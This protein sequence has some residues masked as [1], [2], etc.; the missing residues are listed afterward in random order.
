[1]SR[2]GLEPS[3]RSNGH[4]QMSA[5]RPAMERRDLP[6][7]EAYL[8]QVMLETLEYARE[9]DYTGYD[10]FDGMSSRVLRALPVDNKWVNIAVQESIKR[11]PVN[12]RPYF[13]VEQRQN[14]KGTALFSMA[15]ETAYSLTGDEMYREESRAL[16]DW[17]VDN[18]ADGYA[19]FCGGH[20]HEMQQLDERRPA[21]TPNVVPT[22]Y[23]VKALLRAAEYEGDYATVA[24]TAA[25]FVDEDLKYR[26]FDDGARIVY[27]PYFDGEFYTLNG[28][29]VG[30]R[31]H[32]DL[33]E[34]FGDPA[35]LDRARKLLD[36]IATKQTD[37]GGW[38]YRDPASASHLSMDNH[39][40][41][42]V[43]ESYLRYQEVAGDERYRDTVER[44]LQF[45][46]EYL[47]D[48]NGAPNWDEQKAYPKDI[49]AATQ[50]IIVFSKAGE[51]TFAR[52]IIDWV[53]ANL[54][55]G[56]G[57]FYYQKR[58]FYTK[59]FTLM[60]WC[61][62]WMAYA[63]AVYLEERHLDGGT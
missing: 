61:Q 22:S 3:A 2:E 57:Q 62:A 42:F 54:Y 21:N 33:Y 37:L 55:A 13:L 31:L 6:V 5:D 26:E 60:R 34:E 63:L 28:G 14:F 9:R 24:R 23:G 17:L 30:A 59:R 16:A 53:F 4:G 49:H 56:E 51:F 52:K 15:N 19:G 29:A 38:M 44:A 36:Y 32:V 1:M 58:R 25:A 8:L 48:P 39:H 50:G 43:L 20:T 46:R 35:F 47:F 27:Q 45:H 41:G 18:R 12:V 7:D 40:N 11:A 10:Y